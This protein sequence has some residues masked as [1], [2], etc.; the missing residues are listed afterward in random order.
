MEKVLTKEEW[1]KKRKIRR[2]VRFGVFCVLALLLFIL[3]LMGLKAIFSAI[4]P[5]K[6]KLSDKALALKSQ[7]NIKE[8][9]IIKNPNTRS[10]MELKEI[11][12]IV[13]HYIG[14]SGQSAAE[15]LKEYNEI[16]ANA[17]VQI[18]GSSH[19]IVG[20]NGEIIHCIPDDEIALASKKR[21]TD[22]LS[23]EYAHSDYDGEP[24][25]TTYNALV[26]LTAFLMEKYNLELKDIIR[27]T[28]ITGY[29][30]PPYFADDEL[31]WTQFLAAVQE[32]RENAIK[33]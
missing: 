10:G 33:K 2:Y 14:V 18:Q 3:L 20:F 5:A 32:T 23:I 12:G 8:E 29:P 30:C 21:N 4:F 9:P 24:S 28:D 11:K 25:E 16:D 22:S 19:Y 7:L 1:K 26:K 15:R 6:E 31:A 27:H 13:I 17:E